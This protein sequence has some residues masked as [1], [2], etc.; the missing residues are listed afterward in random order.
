MIRIVLVD[1]QALIRT[2]INS[3]LA[4]TTDIV[5]VGEADSGETALRVTLDQRPDVVLMD[6]RMP[7]GD[8]IQ[9]TQA[10]VARPELAGTRVLV[11]TTFEDDDNVARAL[12]AGAS[13]FIG[14]GIDPTQLVDSIRAVHRGDALL[15]PTATRSLIKRFLDGTRKDHRSQ[16]SVTLDLLTS[17]EVEVLRHVGL[18][19]SNDEIAAVLFI[20]SATVKSHINRS[21]AKLGVHDR[22]QLVVAAYTNGLV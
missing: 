6:I 14:K 11:L 12:T 18:G 1:D 8:G 20:S 7:A 21:M 10:I 3:I 4:G 9:A 22:A 17:R 19:E 15:S 16:P 13:G 5:V 2:A